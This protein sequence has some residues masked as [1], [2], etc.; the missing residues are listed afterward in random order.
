MAD[1]FP[2]S[3]T[4]IPTSIGQIIHT[5]I[6]NASSPDAM[7]YMYQVL[8]QNGEVM[9]AR[10]GDEAPHLTPAQISGIQTLLAAQRALAE[11]TLP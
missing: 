10:F 6:D 9:Y 1:N 11:G 5:L 3:E 7:R 2:A 4:R 8:D